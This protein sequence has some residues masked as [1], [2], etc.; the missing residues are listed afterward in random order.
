MT[1]EDIEKAIARLQ[2]DELAK[3]RAWFEEFDAIQ[4][5]HKIER[6]AQNCKLDRLAEQAIAEF[7]KGG[8]RE[9]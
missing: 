7:R 6:D 8:A 2:P 3:L 4:F 5:N 9:L 1:V